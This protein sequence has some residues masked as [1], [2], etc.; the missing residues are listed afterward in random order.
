MNDC[1]LLG[2]LFDL[3]EVL[4][5]ETPENWRMIRDIETALQRMACP[6]IIQRYLFGKLFEQEERVLKQVVKGMDPD[7]ILAS[8]LPALQNQNSRVRKRV[9]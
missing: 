6:G 5:S 2:D 9:L 3:L 1:S 7:T 4:D 8:A